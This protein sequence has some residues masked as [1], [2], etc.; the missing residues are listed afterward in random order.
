MDTQ[1]DQL[2]EALRNSLMENEKL[3]EAHEAHLAAAREPIAIVSAACR[4]P[5]GVATP[6]Q[7]WRLIAEGRDAVS[8]FPTN[9]G[10][11][12]DGL[13]DPEPG[14]D[15]KCYTREGGFLHDADRFDPGFFNISPSEALIMD[16]QQRVLL[17]V[18]HEAFERAGIP[19]N[20]LKGSRTGV[21]AGVM[22]H[23]YGLGDDDGSTSG[24]SVVS[25][26]VAYTFGLEGPAVTVDTACSSS[27]VALHLAAQA[28]R[29]GE[30]S[31]ALAGG[32]TVMSTPETFV[33]FSQQRGL[34]VDGRCKAF[35]EAADGTGWGEGAGLLLLERLSDARRLGHPV[36]A[37]VRGS[38]VNQDGAS[39][40]LTAPN[41]PSQ[42]RVIRAALANAQLTGVDVDLV[43]GH[44]TGTRLG[45]PIEAQALLA[46]YG[47]DRDGGDPLYLGSVKSNLGHTQAAAGVAGV[48]KLMEAMRHGVMPRTLH[49]DA[50]SSQVDWTSGA[51]ELLTEARP[52]P[53]M[54][55]RPRRAAVSSFGISGTNAHIIIE[56]PADDS[57]STQP[58]AR[59][60]GPVAVALSARS[61]EALTAS[62]AA[63][64]SWWAER[65]DVEVAEV[66]SALRHGRAALEHRTVVVA[67]S[68]EE[69]LAGLGSF[70]S[71]AQ[72]AGVAVTGR[73]SA[74]R[75]GW[76]FTGQ[77]SQWLGMG[78]ELYAAEPV[79]AAA[80]D[81]ACEAL[82]RHLPRP[83]R[84]VVWGE[85]ASLV[86]AT[87]FTQAGLFAVQAGLVAVLRHWGV[88]PDVLLGH[89]VGEISAAYAAGVFGL[90][91]AARLVAA[92]GS[93]MQALP[94][95]GGML[96]LSAALEGVEEL[97]DGTA[98]DVAAVNAPRAV[99][100]SGAVGEL[101]QVTARAAEAGVRATRLSVSHAFHSRL[102]EPMLEEFAQVAAGVTYR[103]PRTA[104]V[105]NVTG[106]VV[107][108]ELT[109]PAYWVRHVREAV[110]FAD[111]LAT[112]RGLGVTRFVE[113]GPEAVLT[114]LTRQSLDEA[115]ELA[116]APLMRRPEE[117]A[118]AQ[119]TLLRAAAALHVRGASVDWHL[120][121]PA[122]HLDLPTYPFQRSRYWLP[123]AERGMDAGSRGLVAVIHPLLG[124]AVSVADTGGTILTGRLSI[125]AEPWLADHAVN[126]TVLLPG[127]AFVELAL[128]AGDEVGCDR[129]EELT[130]VAP[131]VLPERGGVQ[132]QVVVGGADDEGRRELTVHSRHDGREWVCHAQGTVA[133]GDDRPADFDLAAWPPAGAERV[134]TGDPYAA[135]A[136]DGYD[137][138]PTFQGLRQ[139]WRR[140][141]ELFVDIALPEDADA[142]AFG[143]HPALLDAA[144]HGVHLGRPDP[145]G[146]P[147]LPFSWHGVTLWAA[148]ASRL[149]VAVDA[150]GRMRLA[151]EDGRPVGE[152]DELVVR[153][154]TAADL[155]GAAGR[156]D[157]LHRITWTPA[158][159]PE[160]GEPGKPGETGGP[161]ESAE[162]PGLSSRLPVTVVAA[163]ALAASGGAVVVLRAEGDEPVVQVT[164]ALQE[165]LVDEDRRDAVLIVAADR[166]TSDGPM[167]A[168]VAGLV[169]AAQAE[170]PGRFVFADVD[171]ADALA[172][173]VWHAVAVSGEPEWRLR[174]RD[175]FVPRLTRATPATPAT[176]TAPADLGAA[177]VTPP[178][179]VA[180]PAWGAGAVLVTGG[181]GGVGAA[182]ARHLVVEHGVAEVVLLSRS[183][184]DASGA[185]RLVEELT[186]AG[187]RA[188]AVACDVGDRAGLAAVLDTVPDLG[189]V[190]HAAGVLDDAVLTE[191][192]PQRHERVWRPK[193]TA[194][195]H[196]AEL[197]HAR[198]L[199]AFVLVSSISGVLGAAG[200]A[201]YAAANAY[202]DGLAARLRDEGRRATSIAFGL[203]GEVGMGAALDATE[204]RRTE[205]AGLPA[206]TTAEAL[207]AFDRAMEGGDD[208]VVA[209]R[210]LPQLARHAGQRAPLLAELF[211]GSGTGRRS[212]RATAG[213]SRALA[214]K[215]AGVDPAD[216]F[217]MVL[218]LVRTQAAALLGYD[219]AAALDP[220]RPFSE[221]GFDSLST[222]EMRNRLAA[223]TEVR[224]PATLLFDY[225]TVHVLTRHLLAEIA[226]RAAPEA[227][228]APATTVPDDDPI[229][230]V[231]MACRYP[232]GVAAPEE[233]WRLIAEGR[234]AVSAFPADRG[235]DLDALYDPE[236]GVEGRTY[237]RHGAFLHDADQFDPAFFTISPT[238]AL[239]MDPQQR[240]LL[241]TSW[242]AF[243]RAGIDPI[244]L[245]GSRTGVFAGVMY[246]DY[247]PG[248]SSGAIVSGR[249]SYVFGLEGPA[250]T[251][252]TACSSSL[253]ALHLAAQALRSGECSLALAGGV[254]VMSTPET[255]VEFSQQRGLSVDGRC[256]AFAEAADGTGWG[257]GAGLLLLERLS[258]ARRL[259][260]PVLAVVR[261]SA[262]NQDGASNG[263][264]APNG[265]SQQ[266]VIR[267]ALANAQLTGV[268]VDLVEGHGTGTR[269]GDPIEAQALLATY[270]QGREDQEPLYLGSLKSNL[271]HTQ[272]AAGVAGVIKLVE[273][274]R[275]G[276]MPRTLHV[277]APSSQVDWTS[278]AVELLTEARPW[279]AT[280][281]RPR[282][283]AVSSFGISGTNAHVII[284]QV[285]E[286]LESPT[287]K[288]SSDGT[289]A[290]A[291][292]ARSPEALT[293]SAARLASWWSEREDVEVATVASALTGGRAALEHRAVVL[294]SSREEAL[295]SL[296]SFEAGMS[297]A[298]VG[299]VSAG[300]TGWLFTGQGSQWLGMGR[301][302]YA[303]EPVFAAAFDE[304]CEALDRH[305]PRP[306]REVVWG[307]DASL[308]DATVFTQAGLF[309]VQAGLVA[310]L[311][312]WGVSPDVL[313]GHSV[314]EISAAYVAGVFGLEDAARLVAARGS[315]MQALPEGGGMLALAAGRERA[316][317]LISGLLVDVAAVNGPAAVVVSGAVGD[318][319]QVAERADEARVRA[320]RLSVSH[321]FH[322]RLMEPMLEDF[323]AVAATVTYREPAT[324]VVSNVTGRVVSAELTDPAYWVRHV[325]AAVRFSEGLA[326]AGALGVTR[327]VEVG[328]EA[329]LTALA[330]QGLQNGDESTFAPLMRRPKKGTSAQATLL[331]AAATLHV[332]GVSVDWHLPAPARHLDLPTYPFQRSRYWQDS[333]P[334]DADPRRMGQSPTG[335]PLLG[336]AVT[337]AETGGAVL[338]GRLSAETHPWLADH[339]VN[340]V[341]VLPPSVL[342]DF[343]LR[344]ALE[345]DCATVEELDLGAPV[346]LSG[347]AATFVQVSVGAA[348]VSGRRR[349]GVYVRSGDGGEWVRCASGTLAPESPT[350]APTEW[351]APEAEPLDLD[352]IYE[353]LARRGHAYGP[354]FRTVRS[355]WRDGAALYVESALP[356]TPD[357]RSDASSYV[358]HPALLEGVCQVVTALDGAAPEELSSTSAASAMLAASWRGITVAAG[359]G[360]ETLRASFRD[361]R[362]SLLDED[363]VAVGEVASLELRPVS[364]A[365]L[366]AAGMATSAT[367]AL[368][369]LRWTAALLPE[370]ESE[371]GAAGPVAVVGPE[372]VADAAGDVVVCVC[373]LPRT[374]DAAAARSLTGAVLTALRGW[375]ADPARHSST[376]VIV[377]VCDDD[378]SGA[379]APA[380]SAVAGL[381][382][383]AQ[384]E[385]PGRFVLVG[386]DV[387][388]DASL[389]DERT[390]RA[391]ATA[392]EPEWRRPADGT[393]HVARLQRRPPAGDGPDWGTG[394][395]LVT[396][397][398]GGL[399]ALVARRLATGHGVRKLV[400]ASRRGPAAPGAAEL[401]AELR[402]AGADVRAVA[403]DVADREALAG[404]LSTVDELTG[405]VH[406]AG[407]LHDGVLSEQ[408]EDGLDAAWA[409]K[410]AAAWALH[411][412][413]RNLPLRAFVMF[414]SVAG[415][416]GSAGQ[417]NYA[418]ANGFLD[419]LAE[420]RRRQ[421][422][423]AVSIAYGLW[424][425][426]G[427]GAALDPADQERGA[428]IGMP[429]LT[430]AQGLALFDVAVALGEP[431]VVATP[432]LPAVADH[433]GQRAP[434]LTGLFRAATARAAA[435]RAAG[436]RL[437]RQLTAA[438]EAARPDIAL[439]AVQEQAAQVLGHPEGTALEPDRPFSEFGFDSLTTI[440]MR[441]RLGAATG[442][443][444]PAGLL[445]D[446]PTLRALARHLV[447]EVSGTAPA[448]TAALRRTAAAAAA[449]EPIAIVS[450]ACRFP[451]GV[452]SPEDLWRLVADG[453]DA[454]SDFPADR[455][456][457]LARLYD[458]EPGKPG[459]TYTRSG[460]FLTGVD[461]FDPAFFN[462]SPVEAL[463]MDPQQRLFLETTWEAL[464]RAGIDP[465]TLAGS[466]TGVFTGTSYQ[467]YGSRLQQI[468]DEVAGYVGNGTLG[469][470]LSGR[471]SYVFGFEGPAVTVDTACSSSL[472]ALHLAAQALR[473]GECSLALA[474][475]ATVMSTPETFVEFSRQR[476]LSVDGRCKAFAEAADGTGWGEGVGL[477][478]V[479]KLSDARRL[480][481]PVLAVVRG[482]AVNQD[483]ASNG[484]TAP[485]GPSQ[486]RVI[487]AA[488]ANAGVS[489]ADVDLVEAHGT[490]TR[491]GDPIE[492]QAL[493]DTYGT[494]R[495]GAE[496]LY[497]GSVKSNLGHTQAAA[498]V[499][500][501][502]KLVEAMRHGVMPRTLH[503]DAPS[504]QVD[505]SAGAVELLTE[506]RPWQVPGDRPRR[507]A[508]S[509]FG[510]SGTNAH[511]VLEQAVHD[512]QFAVP[513][514]EGPVAMA[515][516]ARSPE[517]L[518]AS[519]A[520][521][522][523][524]WSRRDDVEVAEVAS[525]LAGGRA[526]LEH[527]AVVVA[528]GRE[529]ALTKLAAF[530][531]EW[532]G[533][534][535]GRVSAG[536][537][538]WLFTG[539][540]SQW[541]GMGRELYGAEPVFAAAFDEACEALDRHLP[542]PL[543]EV[544]WGED[545][546]LLDATVF[547][548][549][550]LFAVQAGLVAVLRHWGVSPNVLLGH[551]VGEI[552]AAYAAGVFGLEDAARLVAARGSLMQALPDG[553]GMLA[554]AAGRERA[555]SLISGTAVDIA[556]VNGPAAVVV[557]GAVG[558]LE[559][560]AARAAEAGVRATRL[561][562][563]HAFHSRLMEPMLEEFA[564]VAATVT[565][566]EP[567]TAVVSNV[568]G[569]V[570][571]T[572]LTDPG[573][574][575][576]HVREAVRFADGVATAHGLGV[577]RFVEVGP[578]AVLTALARQTLDEADELTFAPL[579][580][581][582][583][584]GIS[585]QATLLNAAAALYAS[586]VSVDWHLPAPVRHLD[587]PTYPFQRSRYWLSEPVSGSGAGQ[588]SVGVSAAGLRE[589]GHGLLAASVTTAD[590]V[591]TVLTGRIGVSTHPWL[592]DH[593]VAGIALVPGTALLDMALHAAE[594]TDYTEVGEL[595]IAQPL[596]LPAHGQVDV[597]VQ[598]TT[599]GEQ[600]D[601]AIHSR[602]AE[603]PGTPWITHATGTLTRPVAAASRPLAAT[604]PEPWPP[605][606]AANLDV[607]DLYRR[608]AVR[609]FRLGPQFRSVQAA[610]QGEAGLY[611]EV[612]LPEDVDTSGHRIH[613]ALLDGLCQLLA[614][615]ADA[616]LDD[617]APDTMPL[618]SAWRGVR[619]ES[620]DGVL[621]ASPALRLAFT[622]A[623]LAVT[624]PSGTPVASAASVDLHAVPLPDG[625]YAGESVP[626]AAAVGTGQAPT[627]TARRGSG[628]R[629]D[630]E[631]F[632]RE[633]GEQDDETRARSLLRLVREQVAQVLG[634]V[635]AES[636][637][638]DT[639]FSELGFDSMAAVEVRN[640]L[641]RHTGLSLPS[642]LVFDRPTARLTAVWLDGELRPRA[643][644]GADA[645]LGRM[646]TLDALL[647]SASPSPEERDAILTGLESLVQRWRSRT[648]ETDAERA[649]Q[650][651]VVLDDASDD[652]LFAVLD[653]E[654]SGG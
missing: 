350:A 550:G 220:Q 73:V 151:D 652:E 611:V 409:P 53:A 115:D 13:Y 405:V 393:W 248:T 23:D 355:A 571:S 343:A 653:G 386:L 541:L 529:E 554:L 532:T 135:L 483:G 244:A 628:R 410:A 239:T 98:V 545:A 56:Q 376:L 485:N 294:A 165:W 275:H 599:A 504:S 478:L 149:R 394:T 2:V 455:G 270:G 494:D 635:D 323:A 578:E 556:A 86:D 546:S 407:V 445:F 391:L 429:A 372:D 237:S 347:G 353:A 334:A 238:E 642:T 495:D 256:K 456:W 61:P 544:V 375:V 283:A 512:A 583:K 193:A 75:T 632:V 293:A 260:H 377:T 503:V 336:A 44:G 442:L 624:T 181:T 371:P 94:D 67:S 420:H 45:D 113:V 518:T 263:L 277:D 213:D 93:L 638:A 324:A 183:G 112:A 152:V 464:E 431:S 102:M 497:L 123:A 288:D 337:V 574:W 425:G 524:W 333:M 287:S 179:A 320:T 363:G 215:L 96:A 609:G 68:R 552:S 200:Q 25:G 111:G 329:V 471:V 105:S 211:R 476:G 364:S 5:G 582:P 206:L 321:A 631:Q 614:V 610:W 77:G 416:L 348:D 91:D 567:T 265:P 598:V 281:G 479:E 301:E 608:L 484:L 523:S 273:A 242:E 262:V 488:L 245:K 636:V 360:A 496:P 99:V 104:V 212:A 52:W 303:A 172:P 236:P 164:T 157:V 577:T 128:R 381:V 463:A 30:C 228:T 81:E 438:P 592:A 114:A 144:L 551:S 31:L 60:H 459:H 612:A 268:D 106:Q 540:G 414:S 444:L 117:G 647:T 76:L 39:N 3:R 555:E 62:A 218:D 461:R 291:L 234:D 154:V 264:T 319:E 458:P 437:A 8:P 309:A 399:G 640:R 299:R 594:V 395:V 633:L 254:T 217:G 280:D 623:G 137:Y 120:P 133:A 452:T 481:H 602:P 606:P 202:L 304:A 311:R 310:V 139:V 222:I 170:H 64:I 122:R 388:D 338:T 269:L 502:I 426:G 365:E 472:V 525:A 54:G 300:R 82:D 397:G 119:V 58:R 595:I 618:G 148:G 274:M 29:S 537:T 312:H 80:F 150:G 65:D 249:V 489:A 499:A 189:A 296:T 85:D 251:V 506:A 480:G 232:G 446:H 198:D 543:R 295:A 26:R 161:G 88:S 221:L 173:S 66:A 477:L 196:L 223:A 637:D 450:M 412:L 204:L 601:L 10:W 255:F 597:Q 130:L 419:G 520:R 600:A 564:Q 368:Y 591:S 622:G 507:A 593:A 422:L 654:L 247:G 501:V 37:V 194:A 402:D 297:D 168:G 435:R 186:A 34:S 285:P 101:E 282:R 140:G 241:E 646:S 535:G 462:I 19:H 423:P 443:R 566:R 621:S 345:V 42:Q 357:A 534:I 131:L 651:A 542:R 413:T 342:V 467:D 575:A 132:I 89:S 617:P 428:R 253:V 278:G 36:L 557:S 127:T 649:E 569:Q 284:E 322:S 327:F 605:A 87:V 505:W 620:G 252:D 267:A 466:D 385:H 318:L 451:G 83:L 530:A 188:R 411:D 572:E 374:S 15:G 107:S 226:G 307:E 513:R 378:A 533:A 35:A 447:A 182:I 474:G 219:D 208:V 155:A 516:S 286:P 565:Y 142:Q 361:G 257:E 648:T 561:S 354:A 433:A 47:R 630:P 392:A 526:S 178:A 166:A 292:S 11:D 57:E 203:W 272:A 553:G 158:R 448:E 335:H 95:G 549:A 100:V 538:G 514:T 449:D 308:V 302:L 171:D 389:L 210:L 519:A 315:L 359:S 92:R 352:T 584:E 185:A 515:L 339:D 71:D 440:E 197:T 547:T 570:V 384:M 509:S 603:D 159:L 326:T 162:A 576:R 585:A 153:P 317:E 341:S 403:C 6:G 629:A 156:S 568:T 441:N 143:L 231:S 79:F 349:L 493:L 12:L 175:W 563:S 616:D 588:V 607:D 201:N 387:A 454:V 453:V 527:R 356:E 406:T 383:A 469:S 118:S 276:V 160:P 180:P 418:A 176:P 436:G 18:A 195:D 596:P 136:A 641:S 639:A 626:D 400:L 508:V 190:V 169:R 72:G 573:Y 517:A 417:T 396:G 346:V 227:D 560:V 134:E 328:P 230:I 289:V 521:L 233:L 398:T 531:S 590:G 184:P 358:L 536:R 84:E 205:Q 51:V 43:E 511:V 634:H 246:H 59:S 55:D 103:E 177:A 108:A 69:A 470:V 126:G 432:L 382:R 539:Q 627:A 380:A 147:A 224:L 430:V 401:L 457:D 49:V 643:E 498:G 362:L 14:A 250:V 313:L 20:S 110:R 473:A 7:L 74:G 548:Q 116:F 390:W 48:I 331:K 366:T 500:G 305:L 468:P 174:G 33:E 109:D 243:E 644:N 316:E 240:L 141:D 229:A 70:A 351:L 90:E 314:G 408:T 306:L 235:W 604:E 427:M 258:D 192:T 32:V 491:L 558:D 439:R 22:Y 486:Q 163:D 589:S 266:R 615:D 379:S 225:P 167:R 138:G 587:L 613:P 344:A 579:M 325:R 41:G 216:R 21:F 367:D 125:E 146:G 214:R 24:G 28:L 199:S 9:R 259:G 424:E 129:V 340:G 373:P 145:E 559:Q 487:R 562:V 404:L 650:E 27:L 370:P 17:E 490:G 40:G 46:T 191:L 580:R 207:A 619:W 209:A 510:I 261:G 124:A 290:I 63:L 332:S 522:A 482:S 460:A 645:L 298:V 475:G 97:I 415:V 279:P 38:A 369:Q 4:F 421:G 434:L 16:P 187:A 271:G 1:V 330:R 50:P 586:G 78:R 581:R 492:A 121:T 465:A 528:A 625:A